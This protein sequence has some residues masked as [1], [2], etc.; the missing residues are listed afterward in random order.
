[1]E[2]LAIIPARGG[3]K[4]IKKKNIAILNGK[5]LV[6]WTFEAALQSKLISRIVLSSDCDD[7]IRCGIKNG[8]EVPFKRPAELAED[9]TPSI[10]VIKHVVETLSI[11]E[12][13]RPDYIL[14]LQPTS[15]LRTSKHIDDA[16]AKIFN[17]NDADSLVSVVELPHA[18]NPQS[19]MELEGDKLVPFYKSNETYSIRQLKPKYY[20]RNGAAIYVFTYECLMKKNSIYGD[21]ILPFFMRESESIDIDEMWDLEL[22]NYIMNRQV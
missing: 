19:I 15:P 5:P 3:S 21:F 11:N 13:Y 14:L 18:F 10:L 1:M 16:L 2:V 4:G 17:Q 6:E 20:A 22:C 9:N 7:I 8:I 12:G